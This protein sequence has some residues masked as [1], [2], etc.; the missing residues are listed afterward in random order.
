MPHCT[1]I[2]DSAKRTRSKLIASD[3]DGEINA[4]DSTTVSAF[5][6]MTDALS[7]IDSTNLTRTMSDV[8]VTVAVI[9][10]GS[11]ELYV[12]VAEAELLA[13]TEAVADASMYVV[14]P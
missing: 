9:V 5:D 4:P 7:T 10:C 8:A 1:V 6:T 14:T 2:C 13:D 12:A 3:A 11:A